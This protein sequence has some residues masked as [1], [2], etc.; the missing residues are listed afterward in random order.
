MALK[1]RALY[2]TNPDVDDVVV[3]APCRVALN[4]AQLHQLN[5]LVQPLVE[6]NNFG[7]THY[8]HTCRTMVSLIL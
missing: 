4:D 7:I 1:R 3:V 8:L 5:L 2:L 6:D